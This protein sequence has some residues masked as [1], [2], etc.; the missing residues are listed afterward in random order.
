MGFDQE[1][2]DLLVKKKRKQLRNQQP[3]QGG[4]EYQH[5]VVNTD[6]E[7]I[8]NPEVSP[9]QGYTIP[10]SARV[11]AVYPYDFGG[12]VKELKA[13]IRK[14]QADMQAI[15][16]R[17]PKDAQKGI[18]QFLLDGDEVVQKLSNMMN[19]EEHKQELVALKIDELRGLYTMAKAR[20]ETKSIPHPASHPLDPNTIKSKTALVNMITTDYRY[21]PIEVWRYYAK[22]QAMQGPPPQH[23]SPHA[24]PMMTSPPSVPAA[25][26]VG[27][28]VVNT[29]LDQAMLA[30]MNSL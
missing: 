4:D 17:L 7:A 3:N 30:L 5:S 22:Q 21:S 19:R 10:A 6:I 26:V 18:G 28:P 29:A 2:Y 9:F 25:P 16:D 12:K 11:K 24:P 1:A 13:E 8:P 14:A 27:T 23:P 15:T 20:H